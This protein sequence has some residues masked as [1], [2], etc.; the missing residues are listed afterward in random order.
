M[1]ETDLISKIIDQSSRFEDYQKNKNKFID[2]LFP[3]KNESIGFKNSKGTYSYINSLPETMRSR[4][5]SNNLISPHIIDKQYIWKR[6][7]EITEKYN[8]VKII[9]NESELIDDVVQGD[10]GD[11]YFLAATSALAERRSRILKI[12]RGNSE[13]SKYV[14]KM[15][16]FLNGKPIEILVDEFFPCTEE[17][18]NNDYKLKL[19]FSSIEKEL[20]NIWPLLLE[21]AWAKVNG[22]Y[23]N[24]VNGNI[25]QAF[26]FLM[27]C[28]IQVFLHKKIQV[29]EL[30]NIIKDAD[31]KD[32]IICCDSANTEDDLLTEM[33][34]LHNHAYS[35]IS[36]HSI[37]L[38]TSEIVDILKVRNPWG[39]LE[40][41]GDWS[42]SSDKWNADTKKQIGLKPN[43]NNVKND[44]FFYMSVSDYLRFFSNTYV[45][46]YYENYT[47]VFKEFKLN[48][49]RN[50][51]PIS[52]KFSTKTHGY[53]ILNLKNSKIFKNK[54]QSFV[55]MIVVKAIDDDNVSYVGSVSG[56]KD[57]LY[58]EIEFEPRV[59]YKVIIK[60]PNSGKNEYNIFHDDIQ[61]STFNPSIK[62]EIVLGIYYNTDSNSKAHFSIDHNLLYTLNYYDLLL[63]SMEDIS[64]KSKNRENFHAQGENSI[65]RVIDFD[66][67][68]SYGFLLYKNDSS[69]FVRE[70]LE[71]SKIQ[72]IN[73]IP[74]PKNDLL[75]STEEIVNN[76]IYED[77]FESQFVENLRQ[78]EPPISSIDYLLDKSNNL[79]HLDITVAPFSYYAILFEKREEKTNLL[80]ENYVNL[81]YPVSILWNEKKFNAKKSKLNYNNSSIEVYESIIPHSTGVL[82]KYKNKTSNYHAEIK[83]KLDNLENL[84]EYNRE[85]YRNILSKQNITFSLEP[86]TCYSVELKAIDPFKLFSYTVTFDYKINYL[87]NN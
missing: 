79:L 10:L 11:C 57:R 66:Q 61:E 19:A 35:I 67:C 65:Y 18:Q 16:L 30:I 54:K 31:L 82:F 78:A 43:E 39:R 44:G 20:M 2:E 76:E 70:R 59:E 69:A 73:V 37:K 41:N 48:E 45:C 74:F 55:S 38:R 24:I 26:E 50:Y 28:P 17:N 42:D 21:K 53:F 22:S 13:S 33:G 4:L 60:F 83:I 5:I 87:I 64:H 52:I 29:T 85:V 12:F 68:D 40:W 56:S 71:I 6:L 14:F 58:I 32:F 86:Q 46:K 15:N 80:F 51:I 81:D 49:K 36:I 8:I 27:P 9:Q 34:L 72:N 3:T 84:E 62:E 1:I 7:S 75:L 77:V 23:K 63:K 25:V 47:Y